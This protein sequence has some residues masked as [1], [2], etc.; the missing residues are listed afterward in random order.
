MNGDQAGLAVIVAGIIV[1]ALALVG[2]LIKSLFEQPWL[3][4]VV[5]LAIVLFVLAKRAER[6]ERGGK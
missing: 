6:R 5:A 4:G 2:G 1:L 3:L